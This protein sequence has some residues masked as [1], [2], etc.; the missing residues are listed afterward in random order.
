MANI[1]NLISLNLS[2]DFIKSWN[3][4]AFLMCKVFLIMLT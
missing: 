4:D 3:G 2:K 1:Q